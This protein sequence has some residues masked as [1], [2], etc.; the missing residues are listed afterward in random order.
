MS[1]SQQIYIRPP[2]QI[3]LYTFFKT[4]GG[5]GL[6]PIWGGAC[7]PWPQ[8]RTAPAATPGIFTRP[9]CSTYLPEV[10]YILTAW[11]EI[12]VRL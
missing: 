7:A 1:A 2:P 8:R 11:P 9:T 3:L 10:I 5:R 6:D 4:I 12:R